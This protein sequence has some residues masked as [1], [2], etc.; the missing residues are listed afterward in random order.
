MFANIVAIN[1]FLNPKI[2]NEILQ[3]TVVWSKFVAQHADLK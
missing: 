3:M 2:N 1:V